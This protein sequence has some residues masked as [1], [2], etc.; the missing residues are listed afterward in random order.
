MPEDLDRLLNA[1]KPTIDAGGRL[2]LV[3]T[4]D[5]AKP[6]SA[7]KRIYGA[8]CGAENGYKSIFLSWSARPGR[9]V[10]WYEEQKRDVLART[11]ATDDLYQEYPATD[12]EA[13][14]PRSLDRRFAAEWLRRCDRAALS[15]VVGVGPAIPGLVIWRLPQ[16]GETFV[17]GADPAEG[18]PQSDNSAASVVDLVGEQVAA[19]AGRVEPA[20]FGAQIAA[21]SAFFNGAAALVERNNHGHAVLLWLREFSTVQALPGL[22]KKPGWATTGASKP[23]AYDNAADV[24][25]AGA[26]RNGRNGFD[27][28]SLT[29]VIRDPRRLRSWA[30]SRRAW[31][32][33]TVCMMIG[34]RRTC[35]RW[36][37]CAFCS[38]GPL[39]SVPAIPPV[40]IIAE[41]DRGGWSLGP[42]VPG[43]W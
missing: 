36:P 9:S 8:A 43:A 40:D 13:L 2:I 21:V 19:W 24:L 1:V 6:Q 22:D 32:R 28:D 7:F 31:P 39:V 30:T 38:V 17:I 15:P 27:F 37:H 11:A 33:R 14:A 20:A 3:S 4:A 5:K 34:R 25:R 29:A 23:M 42:I 41:A 18:N 16:L 26:G 12:F 10:E 35:W